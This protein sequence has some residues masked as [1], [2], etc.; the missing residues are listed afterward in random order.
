MH[1]RQTD[2]IY[3][4]LKPLLFSIAYRMVGSVGEA[5]D[6][7]QEAFLRYHRAQSEGE[8]IDSPKGFL[9]TVTTRLAIDYLRSARAQREEYV[10]EWLPEPLL[11]D[12]DADTAQHAETADSLSLAFLVLLESLTPVERAVFLLHDVFG[13]GYEEVSD[14]VGKSE[15]NTRQL[16][17]RA[18]RHVDDRR[19]RFEA[20]REERDRLAD[21]FFEAVEEGDTDG[22]VGLLAHDVVIYGDGGGKAPSWRRIYGRDKVSRLLLGLT[23]QLRRLDVTVRRTEINGQPGALFLDRDG[24]LISIFSLDVSDGVV[25]TIRGI[26][27]PDKLGHLGPLAD[28]RALLRANRGSP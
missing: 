27:N 4:E 18:R 14:V 28:L 1:D 11:T 23:D 10:G 13:Y 20:S 6:I 12:P 9:S 5:E 25:Q 26:V 8:D 19:P 21:R 3:D 2:E 15:D 24:L 7:V 16:A 17:V 22:L